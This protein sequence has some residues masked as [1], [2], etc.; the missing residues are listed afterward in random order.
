VSVWTA[1]R[2]CGGALRKRRFTVPAK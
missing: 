2:L 1:H